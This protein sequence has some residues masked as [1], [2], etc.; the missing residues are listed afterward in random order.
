M[1]CYKLTNRIKEAFGFSKESVLTTD[2]ENYIL[3]NIFIAPNMTAFVKPSIRQG[4]LPR[5]LHEVL[6]TRIMVKKS[7]KLYQ[8]KSLET[9][10]LDSRQYALKMVANVTYG[11]TTAGFSGRM[12]CVEI[13]DAIVALARRTLEETMNS[14]SNDLG[15]IATDNF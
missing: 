12:P 3:D 6:N 14:A 11:Y 1:G 7:M 5:M 13:A 8:P 15:L 2:E 10:I 9:R 4:L